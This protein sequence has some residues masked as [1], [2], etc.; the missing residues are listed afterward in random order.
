[1]K[2]HMYGFAFL[3]LLIQAFPMAYAAGEG[4]LVKENCAWEYPGRES[5]KWEHE[6]ALRALSV[7]EETIKRFVARIQRG[8]FD[9]WVHISPQQGV[10][11]QQL[12]DTPERFTIDG[13][14]FGKRKVCYGVFPAWA[15]MSRKEKARLYVE[16]DE[17][18][19]IIYIAVPTV[20]NNMTK[21]SLIER[22]RL[23][24]LATYEGPRVGTEAPKRKVLK[25]AVT[26][27]N[28]NVVTDSNSDPVTTTTYAY[29]SPQYKET[30]HNVR[31]IQ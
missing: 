1:M 16:Q 29:W 9:D 23:I 28:G 17:N 11:R 12:G 31:V 10:V 22:P 19:N 26:D 13:M 4:L 6:S 21:L 7:P 15:D 2:K 20:C 30:I 3:F 8:Q 14:V 25:N 27:S 5:S 24:I 18:G